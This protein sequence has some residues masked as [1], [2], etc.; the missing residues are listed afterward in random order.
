LE[1]GEIYLLV[2]HKGLSRMKETWVTYGRT[3][4]GDNLPVVIW[5]HKP[6][7][8][9]INKWYRTWSPEEYKDA[10]GVSWKLETAE[11]AG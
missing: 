6:T 7:E 5:K 1:H 11:F 8:R 4:S 3:E 9:E 2:Q 10:G